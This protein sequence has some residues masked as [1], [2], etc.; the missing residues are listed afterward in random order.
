MNRETPVAGHLVLGLLVIAVAAGVVRMRQGDV[1]F[2]RKVFT[3]LMRGRQ[4]VQRRIDWEH[5]TAM[6][7]NVAGTYAR[8]PTEQDKAN[9]RNSFI[10]QAALA[11]QKAGGNLRA[12]RRWRVHQ[13]DPEQWVV[14]V[15]YPPTQK[16]LLLMLSGD[17]PKQLR[18]IQW[19]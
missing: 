13:R 8:L 1:A 10:E 4:T 5:L 15:D 9:Y 18:G 6:G 11:F 19:Q 3:D 2:G 7:V 16:T 17:H 14:A 12:F